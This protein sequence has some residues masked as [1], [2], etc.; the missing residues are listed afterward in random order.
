MPPPC[1]F[2]SAGFCRNGAKCK[3]SH[4]ASASYSGPRGPQ[5]G[6][7]PDHLMGPPRD[8]QYYDDQ[9]RD[10]YCGYSD[11]FDHSR[12]STRDHSLEEQYHNHYERS[13]RNRENENNQHFENDAFGRKGKDNHHFSGGNYSSRANAFE[14]HPTEG[15]EPP[16][17]KKPRYQNNDQSSKNHFSP[18]NSCTL[19]GHNHVRNE[20]PD[21][22][23]SKNLKGINQ[24][25]L[26]SEAGKLAA[27]ERRYHSGGMCQDSKS[28]SA[29]MKND[30][31]IINQYNSNSNQIAS[32]PQRKTRSPRKLENSQ[33][34]QPM[35]NSNAVSSHSTSNPTSR[36]SCAGKVEM[37]STSSASSSAKNSPHITSFPSANSGMAGNIENSDSIF[38]IPR[39]SVTK[40]SNNYILSKYAVPPE[41]I[42][43]KKPPTIK[44]S[45]HGGPKTS[46]N[47]CKSGRKESAISNESQAASVDAGTPKSNSVSFAERETFRVYNIPNNAETTN[48]ITSSGMVSKKTVGNSIPLK[49]GAD[50]SAASKSKSARQYIPRSQ[51]ALGQL[52]QSTTLAATK[53]GQNRSFIENQPQIATKPVSKPQPGI[54]PAMKQMTYKGGQWRQ[55]EISEAAPLGHNATSVKSHKRSRITANATSNQF[56]IQQSQ[57]VSVSEHTDSMSISDS[58]SVSDSSSKNLETKENNTQ[59]KVCRDQIHAEHYAES[60]KQR[61]RSSTLTVAATNLGHT[62]RMGQPQPQLTTKTSS[63]PTMKTQPAINPPSEPLTNEGG[64]TWL[65]EFSQRSHTCDNQ[66]SE[67]GVASKQ[68]YAGD[69]SKSNLSAVSKPQS[70]K[71]RANKNEEYREIHQDQ[72]LDIN[73]LKDST[74]PESMIPP[75]KSSRAVPNGLSP[76]LEK[77]QTMQR[78]SGDGS[79]GKANDGNKGNPILKHAA[80]GKR[81]KSN[82]TTSLENNVLHGVNKEPNIPNNEKGK[83]TYMAP[84]CPEMRAVSHVKKKQAIDDISFSNKMAPLEVSKAEKSKYTQ[85]T[86][87]ADNCKKSS[88]K[89]GNNDEICDRDRERNNSAT[90]SN[91]DKCKENG[92]WKKPEVIGRENN[93]RSQILSSKS[94]LDL[95]ETPDDKSATD[96]SMH[97]GMFST[98][99]T[100][101]AEKAATVGV[102]SDPPNKVFASDLLLKN[103]V[104]VTLRES[105]ARQSAECNY[106]IRK[107]QTKILDRTDSTDTNTPHPTGLNSRLA[108]GQDRDE[109]DPQ[110]NARGID[111]RGRNKEQGREQ[112]RS[113]RAIEAKAP[114]DASN[115]SNEIPGGRVNKNLHEKL[116]TKA[117]CLPMEDIPSNQERL[118]I[119]RYLTKPSNGSLDWMR[120]E[121]E[122]ITTIQKLIAYDMNEKALNSQHRKDYNESTMQAMSKQFDQDLNVR[123]TSINPDIAL[124]GKQ[125]MKPAEEK[126]QMKEKQRK[127]GN[128]LLGVEQR[129]EDER[130]QRN[131]NEEEIF[132]NVQISAQQTLRADSGITNP[133]VQLH[134]EGDDESHEPPHLQI[135]QKPIDDECDFGAM[136]SNAFE[137]AAREKSSNEELDQ[138]NPITHHTEENENEDEDQLQQEQQ[139]ITSQAYTRSEEEGLSVEHFIVKQKQL[140]NSLEEEKK[141]NEL[142]RHLLRI[143]SYSLKCSLARQNECMRNSPHADSERE[144]SVIPVTNSMASCPD[145]T[146]EANMKLVGGFY[147]ETEAF[148]YL[149]RDTALATTGNSFTT[150]QKPSLQAGVPNGELE[151]I[152]NLDMVDGKEPLNDANSSYMKSEKHSPH[153]FHN[154]KLSPVEEL[155]VHFE[156]TIPDM[157]FITGACP[158]RGNSDLMRCCTNE[159]ESVFKDNPTEVQGSNPGEPAIP[160]AQYCHGSENLQHESTT[161]SILLTDHPMNGNGHIYNLDRASRE[162]PSSVNGITSGNNININPSYSTPIVHQREIGSSHSVNFQR[163]LNHSMQCP[164]PPED[165]VE[166]NNTSDNPETTFE[167]NESP[168]SKE[169]NDLLNS[170]E[171]PLVL[172]NDDLSSNQDTL[173]ENDLNEAGVGGRKPNSN[174]KWEMYYEELVK[175]KNSHGHLQVPK[176]FKPKAAFLGFLV[177]V[178]CYPSRYFTVLSRFRFY[179]FSSLKPLLLQQSWVHRQKRNHKEGK[180]TGNRAEKLTSLG[181][182]LDATK[183]NSNGDDLTTD[184]KS[185]REITDEPYAMNIVNHLCSTSFDENGL[186]KQFITIMCGNSGKCFEIANFF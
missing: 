18:S 121:C 88:S 19:K 109:L 39:N 133:S 110:V 103:L 125:A 147:V 72:F 173:N 169:S 45:S 93:P 139:Q 176:E 113:P 112:G 42:P 178:L 119:E 55:K 145:E 68:P 96:H 80:S 51:R 179:D 137:D 155:D 115:L 105:M 174:G 76:A 79:K 17:P 144:S 171:S 95:S 15:F 59:R 127:I 152:E 84:Q 6:V 87:L 186:P 91:L 116:I 183:Y 136:W 30:T 44:V 143:V 67:A 71:S 3:F 157:G 69:M 85:S 64:Q 167:S 134:V 160:S 22:K 61:E 128:G 1:K 159:S 38:R 126:V 140:S 114:N 4:D 102:S 5:H 11:H 52:K 27:A 50:D 12:S 63:K 148:E 162:E 28:Q 53:Q 175:F 184:G 138:R 43:P 58:S 23:C 37:N 66:L 60:A 2:F 47:S 135:E 56:R 29:M 168:I 122:L 54:K 46:W 34:K 82:A 149:P 101:K 10:S 104:K 62:R 117:R 118:A 49:P 83:T 180:L 25:H 20:C 156:E 78:D 70:K 81:T 123:R 142:E 158:D 185:D 9:R 170:N 106:N 163:A 7:L 130:P 73:D 86:D 165:A 146:H 120:E 132:E 153:H 57:H 21:N 124:I 111:I 92:F 98:V 89:K 150:A 131:K 161:D 182:E 129:I 177:S 48:T 94:V 41:K 36:A 107:G 74:L 77:F 14:S 154:S 24:W 26:D 13:C 108:N 35:K 33:P 166:T 99:E 75:E 32:S 181:I 90:C 164:D 65:S 100:R 16:A 40:N 8:S 172:N 151:L 31:S 97:N 141:I